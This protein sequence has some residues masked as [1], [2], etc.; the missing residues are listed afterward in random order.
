MFSKIAFAKR[1][2]TAFWTCD[3]RS[4]Q[5]P[6]TLILSVFSAAANLVQLNNAFYPPTV[7]PF[8]FTV[9][10]FNKLVLCL[11]VQEGVGWEVGWS[12]S[13]FAELPILAQRLWYT[14]VLKTSVFV[15]PCINSPFLFGT[16]QTINVSVWTEAVCSLQTAIVSAQ[17]VLRHSD[18][19]I[20]GIGQIL[21]SSKLVSFSPS[22]VVL[23][24]SISHSASQNTAVQA[25]SFNCHI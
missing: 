21:S 14:E 23:W 10:N 17:D 9:H 1:Q 7:F 5:S 2:V 25:R 8:S 22:L 15:C 19:T 4:F 6:W 12:W 11:C 18:G 20:F 16:S 24:L 3:K 13:G